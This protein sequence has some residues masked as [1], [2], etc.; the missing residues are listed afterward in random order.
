M[1]DRRR[2]KIPLSR[3]QSK[4]SAITLGF[5][6][7]LPFQLAALLANNR[8]GATPPH[9]KIL[10]TQDLE[11]GKLKLIEARL[12]F[13]QHGFAL[14]VKE[15]G[16]EKEFGMIDLKAAASF[17]DAAFAQDQ[18]VRPVPS[19]STMTAHSL[20][21]IR[22]KQKRGANCPALFPKGFELGFAATR[23]SP[24][25]AAPPI[26]KPMVV[27]SGT[28]VVVTRAPKL[29][30]TPPPVSIRTQC[31]TALPVSVVNSQ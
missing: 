26:S 19:A 4:R 29:S 25:K 24:I 22:I 20:K 14:L 18:I 6:T 13:G 5:Q 12:C 16:E 30:I 10:N 3:P 21:A 27:G 8:D 7:R 17:A 11:P 2:A 15:G 1:R 9:D 31:G 23:A 28:A